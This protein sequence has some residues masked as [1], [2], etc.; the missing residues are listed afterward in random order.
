MTKF[1]AFILSVFCTFTY[2]Q[3]YDFTVYNTSNSGIVANGINHIATDSNGVLWISTSSGVSTLNGGTWTNYTTSNSSIASNSI[4]KIQID[5]LNRKWMATTANGIVMFNGTTWT[6]YTT[7]NSNLPS[8][9]VNDIAVDGSNNLWV[10]TDSGLSKFNGTTWTNYSAVTNITSVATD[11][12]NTPWVTAG[13]LLYKFNGTSFN[14]L[15]DGAARILKIDG[16]FI[17]V[18]QFDGFAYYNLEG[19]LQ[20][21]YW[22]S[23]SCVADCSFSSLDVAAGKVWL[24]FYGQCG[25][26]GVQNFTDCVGY[27]PSNSNMPE[28]NIRS[29]KTQAST[30]WVG[31]N[32]SGLVKMTPSAVTPTGCF[33]KIASQTVTNMAIKNDGTLWAWGADINGSV[34]NGST[35]TS[36][37]SA[38][39]QIGNDTTWQAIWGGAYYGMA[40]KTNGTLWGWGQNTSNLGMGENAGSVVPA[41]LQV[42]TDTDWNILACGGQHVLAIKDNGTLWTWGSNIYGQVGLN[43]SWSNFFSPQQLGS[44]TWIAVSGGESHSL[45]IKSDGTL[46]SWGAN[47]KGQLGIGNNGQHSAPVQVGNASNWV[48][49]AAAYGTSFAIKSDGTLWGWGD[50]TYGQIGDGTAT[51]KTSPVQIGTGTNWQIIS[52][53]GGHTLA[54]KTDGTLWAWGLNNYGQLGNGTTT[55]SYTPMQLGTATN[56]ISVDG[57]VTSTIALKNDGTIQTWGRNYF[58]N[59]GNGTTTS[60]S[61]PLTLP[62]PTSN[63]GSGD[64]GTVDEMKAYPNPVHDLLTLSLDKEIEKVS[65]FNLLGQQVAVKRV[66]RSTY[67]LSA[68]TPGTYVLQVE[69]GQAVKTVKIVKQ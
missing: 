32:A 46:W 19:T 52:P 47:D 36:N 28:N 4:R 43:S 68:L 38:P 40:M 56:W 59:L 55:S 24:G 8:N 64:F 16:D 23:N 34:G 22:M 54:I 44:S 62:C 60:S 10:A 2:A 61:T 30:I 66:D 15:T 20:S 42:G 57:N 6:N 1:Y 13:N 49:V 31:T 26:G 48:K 33:G 11:W 21:V 63:L 27:S 65:V 41:P 5:G 9:A 7:A 37:V 25:T 45:G 17:Y 69:A 67:D 39:S 29:I 12:S 14:A 35:L 50:N 51:D 18:D 58:G 53:A 3:G